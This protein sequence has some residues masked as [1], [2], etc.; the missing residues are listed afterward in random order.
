MLA[1]PKAHTSIQTKLSHLQEVRLVDDILNKANTRRKLTQPQR[2]CHLA[3]CM[4]RQLLLQLQAG[5]SYQPAAAAR[6]FQDAPAAA[7]HV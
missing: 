3:N 2:V 6:I 1:T 4:R 5:T 7:A